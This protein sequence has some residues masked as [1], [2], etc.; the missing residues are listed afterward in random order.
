MAATIETTARA[1]HISAPR[2]DGGWRF[3]VQDNG[4]GIDAQH[5]DR[6]F[7]IFRRLHGR[8]Q[9][10]G[11]GRGLAIAKKI[12]ERHGGRIGVE[13]EPGRG[14]AFFFTL[15]ASSEA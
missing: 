5:F 4:I 8:E 14:T 13:S 12:V 3:S 6:I 9:Y 15:P 7:V 11:T 1:D 2:S 10:G